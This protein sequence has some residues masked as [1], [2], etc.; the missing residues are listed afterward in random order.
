M[1]DHDLCHLKAFQAVFAFGPVVGSATG[2]G[3]LDFGTAALQEGDTHAY[4]S[5]FEPDCR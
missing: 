4:T 5:A 3:L 1:Q 2:R